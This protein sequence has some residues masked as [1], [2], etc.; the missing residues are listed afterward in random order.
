MR[1]YLLIV[2]VSIAFVSCRKEYDSHAKWEV[3]NLNYTGDLDDIFALSNDTIM[4][5]SRFDDTYQKTCIFESDNAGKTWKQ[6]CFDIL[7][8]GGF[9]NFYCFNHLKIY[10]GNYRTYNGGNSWQQVGFNGV[11]MYFFNNQVGIYVIGSSIYKTTDGGMTAKLVFDHTSYEGFNFIQFLNSEI[12]YASGGTSFDSYN[13]GIMVKT[14]DGGNT[15]QTLP[16]KFKSIIGMSFVTADIGY[17]IINLHEGDVFWTYKSGA[18][19]LK[20][21]DGGDTWISINNR[22]YEDFNMIPF[23]CYFEDEKHGFLCGGSRIVYTVD[24]GKTWKQEYD[25]PSSDYAL[26]KMIFTSLKTGFAVGN[27]GLLLKRIVY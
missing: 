19:L 7:N 16:Q 15:W 6:N 14:T 18:E 26:N 22:L 25:N 17:I 27:N 13:S 1:N 11:P 23:Q 10:S 5:L 2:I 9:S 3:I 4:L 20:T 12:G 21:T 24:G 8:A